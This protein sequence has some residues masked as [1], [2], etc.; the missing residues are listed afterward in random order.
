MNTTV[1]PSLVI[2][3]G[4][5][6]DLR[7]STETISGANAPDFST[8]DSCNSSAASSPTTITLQGKATPQPRPAGR[9]RQFPWEV[10]GSVTSSS[11]VGE[12]ST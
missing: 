2:I 7:M 11:W 12:K 6:D 8:Q 10:M 3:S 5:P 4:G 1:A 9:S